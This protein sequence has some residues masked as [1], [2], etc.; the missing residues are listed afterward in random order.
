MKFMSRV[1]LAAVLFLTFG[2][3]ALAQ[4]APIPTS[5]LD[6]E[7]QKQA[8]ERNSAGAAKFTGAGAGMGMGLAAIGAIVGLWRRA[9]SFA[10]FSAATQVSL[11]L[12]GWAW[13]QFPFVVPD[14]LTIRA[15][16]A[17]NETL[18]LLAVGLAV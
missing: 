5:P 9:Y 2:G 14:R 1:A 7:V 10:R 12:W 8:V 17:P 11:I 15:A 18:V 4:P 13:S 6:K 16:A 3:L